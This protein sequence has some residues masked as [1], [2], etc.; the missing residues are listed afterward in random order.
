MPLLK[1]KKKEG[2][3]AASDNTYVKKP[4]IPV[5]RDV[6]F[7]YKSDFKEYNK[8]DS[9]DYIKGYKAGLQDD[10]PKRTS[11]WGKRPESQLGKQVWV[12]TNERFNEGYSEGKDVSIKKRMLFNKNKKTK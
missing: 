11:Y 12:G 9:A 8:K 7:A 3:Q 10:S 6:K 2:Q 4:T 1:K 5:S